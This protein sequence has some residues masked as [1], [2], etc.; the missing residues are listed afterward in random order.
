[1]DETQKPIYH[2]WLRQ[3]IG[4]SDIQDAD[5]LAPAI[6]F[7]HRINWELHHPSPAMDMAHKLYVNA[8]E[9]IQHPNSDSATN[10]Q[11]DTAWQVYINTVASQVAHAMDGTQ[12]NTYRLLTG[13]SYRN[14]IR[15]L[16]I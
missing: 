11:M 4:V 9:L 15:E 7:E 13:R 14:N 16:L 6:Y 12:I 10:P 8:R 1:M 5:F 3:Q 2:A